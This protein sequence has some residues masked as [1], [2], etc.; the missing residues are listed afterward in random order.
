MRT[1]A[2]IGALLAGL[3]AGA[4]VLRE[5]WE[6]P[7]RQYCP[8]D[9]CHDGSWFDVDWGSVDWKLTPTRLACF[10][11]NPQ[12]GAVLIGP[13]DVC[14]S[15]RGDVVERRA[16]YEQL[17]A[18]AGRRRLLALGLAGVMVVTPGVVVSIRS[19]TRTRRSAPGRAGTASRADGPHAP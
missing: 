3:V 12:P 6:L 5:G 19:R 2:V 16:T 9:A 7:V 18:E 4:V 10:E 1:L 8:T 14:V 11:T 17:Q 15:S 13:G